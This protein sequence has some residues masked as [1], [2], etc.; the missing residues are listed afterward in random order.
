MRASPLSR[1]ERIIAV[2]ILVLAL[3]SR[4]VLLGDRAMSHDESI[5]T[6]FSWNLYAGHGFQHNPM[7]HGPL[8]FELTALTYHVFG[9]SDF[10]SRASVALVGVALV[11]APLLF[12]RWIGRSGAIAASVLL[13]ISPSITYYSRYV[14]HDALLM[15]TAVLLLWLVLE[16]LETGRDRWLSW[17]VACFSVMFATKEAAYFY[18]AIYVGLFFLPFAHRVL[19]MPWEKKRLF[20]VFLVLLA[21]AAVLG[22]GF[23]ASFAAGQTTEIPLDEAGNT[24]AATVTIPLW[25]RL[26]GTLAMLA[27]AAA[28]V[29]VGAGIGRQRLRED[30]LFD[31]LMVLGS[32][33]LPLGSAF[34]IKFAAGVDMDVVYEAV[35]TGNF[36]SVPGPTVVA[37]FAVVLATLAVSAAFGIWWDRRR[38]PRVALIHYGIFTVLYTSIFTWGFGAISGLVGG[39]AYWLA[40]HGVERGSQPWYYYVFTGSLYEY[41]VLALTAVAGVAAV[42]QAVRRTD[43]AQVDDGAEEPIWSLDIVKLLPAFLLAW[44]LISWV[45][46]SYAGEKMPWLL[47][48]IVLPSTLLTGWWVGRWVDGYSRQD[49]RSPSA[50]TWTFLGALLLTV[51]GAVVLTTSLAQLRGPLA[52]GIPTAGPTLAQLNPM[53]RALGGLLGAAAGCVGLL[54][55]GRGLAGRERRRSVAALV[56]AV[57]A[58]L[59]MRTTVMLCFVNEG[60]PTEFLV[61]AHGTPDIKAMLDRVE[62]V[63]WATTGTK[64][65]VRVAY[66]EDGSWPLTWYMVYYP[67]NYFYSTTPD[68]EQ[69]RECPVVI[70]GTNQFG[71]VEEILGHEYVAYD[72]LYLWWPIQDYFNLTGERLATSL[73]DPEMRA[74]LWDIVWLRDYRRYAALKNPDNP[75]DLAKWPL[76]KEMRLYVRRDTA[77]AIW[78]VTRPPGAARYVAPVA[79][80]PPDPYG[81]GGRALPTVA[82]HA[83]PGAMVR[84]MAAV[85]DGTVYVADSFNHRVWHLGPEGVI[86]SFGELGAGPG[87]FNEPW[88]IAVDGAGNIYVADTWNH[89]VQ[90]F[91]ADHRFVTSWGG[92]VQTTEL[93]A[94]GANGLFYGPRDIAVSPVGEVFVTDTGNK[95][96]QV[97]SSDGT[98]LREFG[99]WGT[100]PGKLDEP[101]GISVSE[102]GLV[103]VADTWNRRVQVF[104]AYGN[105]LALWEVPGWSGNNVEEKPFLAWGAGTLYVAD[106]SRQRVLAFSAEGEYAWS[107]SAAAGA[108]LSFPL[109]LAADG[110]VLYVSDVHTS[111]VTAYQ[112][113]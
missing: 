110:D 25:G 48:H 49:L 31:V 6:K 16:Y 87:Q 61:Y 102:D 53:G 8:L 47:V 41:L 13:L 57:L 85:G 96:V 92:L 75:F 4:F 105:S 9:V 55:A 95:R 65:E 23:L 15:L 68:A 74:A 11:M 7:M 60:L 103:A 93:G 70:A 10:T 37:L 56:L 51:A 83:F 21:V 38:W 19:T 2:V 90:M 73:R 28:L 34:L 94:D 97:F 43:D 86:G 111:N 33:T 72:Y 26:V 78:P 18:T 46:Y 76:R 113:P 64:D 27:M 1:R 22:G 30:R 107:M 12:R 63:S 108:N 62:D 58:G 89:R 14:R 20:R 82:Q 45:A 66:G 42:T 5:H 69:L 52:A 29:V 104:D 106:P 109:G 84:G 101:V 77:H 24:T 54:R 98:F 3:V 50:A 80:E 39:L 112:L 36:T 99:G 91:D 67:N 79:T 81:L 40:Q 35:R 88:G 44:A 100:G 17:M 32:L 71:A 59:T